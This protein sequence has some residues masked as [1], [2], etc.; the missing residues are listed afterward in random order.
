MLEHH[1]GFFSSKRSMSPESSTGS[2]LITFETPEVFQVIHQVIHE[3]L[4]KQDGQ[5]SGQQ[6]K[7]QHNA[8]VDTN[9]ASVLSS[10]LARSKK[11]RKGS[12]KLEVPMLGQESLNEALPTI[13]R[14]LNEDRQAGSLL[15]QSYTEVR[16]RYEDGWAETFEEAI[17]QGK[18]SLAMQSK[19]TWG[20][21]FSKMWEM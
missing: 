8:H 20:H 6:S 15:S 11:S 2:H 14:V 7:E 3:E 16:T 4:A 5:A 21:R 1:A 18:R 12:R 9:N 17:S 13:E 19:K 10:R